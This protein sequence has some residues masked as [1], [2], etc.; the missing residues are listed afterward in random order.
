MRFSS[1]LVA[2]IMKNSIHSNFLFLFFFLQN[3]NLF[4]Y[5]S[6]VFWIFDINGNGIIELE[7]IGHACEKFTEYIVEN[8]LKSFL[9]KNI[10]KL[11]FI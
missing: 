1:I 4:N 2:K 6:R 3:T 10:S 8:M 9:Y 7:D 11:L 5:F